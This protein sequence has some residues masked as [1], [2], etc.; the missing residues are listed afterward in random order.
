MSLLL[1]ITVFLSF[2]G[3]DGSI[4]NCLVILEV[5]TEFWNGCI[6]HFQTCT[7]CAKLKS[8][9]QMSWTLRAQHCRL[10]LS[11][12]MKFTR[13]SISGICMTP[14]STRND[15][16]LQDE[17]DVTL[18]SVCPP[19]RLGFPRLEPL[20]EDCGGAAALCAA[21]AEATCFWELFL[22]LVSVSESFGI[23]FDL[24]HRQQLFQ[25]IVLAL[26]YAQ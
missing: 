8:I 6:I 13:R 16:P 7:A 1:F 5:S 25:C 24:H 19:N 4:M 21:A 17:S 20:S 22:V 11:Y 2:A 14:L 15:F 3:F 18:I 23:W 9:C 26:I 10:A 12:F